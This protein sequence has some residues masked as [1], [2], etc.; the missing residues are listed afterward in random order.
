MDFAGGFEFKMPIGT[1][2]SANI[3]PDSQTGIGNWTEEAFVSRFKMYA[4]SSYQAPV[5]GKSD[6][7]TI[8]PWRMYAGMKDSDLKAHIPISRP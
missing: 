2:R 5:L 4:D 3:T 1:L 8:M 7:N 6:F